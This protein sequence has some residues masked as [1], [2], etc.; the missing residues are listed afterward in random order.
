MNLQS[1]I[2]MALKL[3]IVLNVFALGLNATLADATSLLRRPK[4]LA[5]AFL[6]MNVVMPIF[7]AIV[8]GI[9]DLHPAVKIALVALSLS[10]VPPILPK[11]ALKAGGYHTLLTLQVHD[12]LVLDVPHEE[13]P[14]M[15]ELVRHQMEHAIA[16]AAPLKTDISVGPNWDGV[17]DE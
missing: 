12:E 2:L 4:E 3:S 16:L 5:K 8:V 9:F 14:A 7:A 11:K 17:S 1:L 13:V 15:R 6:A 10:P